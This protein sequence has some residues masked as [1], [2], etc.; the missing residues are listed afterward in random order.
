MA[1]QFIK[2]GLVLGPYPKEAPQPRQKPMKVLCLG[3]SRTA[4]M[5]TYLGMQ[6]LGYKCYHAWE[7][8][9]NTENGV[10]PF[11]RKALEAK[12]YGKPFKK[13][14]TAEDFDEALWKY[15]VS[16]RIVCFDLY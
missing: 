8:G 10:Y 2:A 1:E 11:W 15:D 4:T 13:L 16:G 7:L 6:K 9:R 12:Y 5:S 14:K 3:L